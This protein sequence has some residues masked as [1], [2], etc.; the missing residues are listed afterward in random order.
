MSG[1]SYELSYKFYLS[2]VGRGF[3]SNNA[4]KENNRIIFPALTKPTCQH[5]ENE[6]AADEAGGGGGGGVGGTAA[7]EIGG[8]GVLI[9]MLEGVLIKTECPILFRAPPT[10]PTSTF[11]FAPS[12]LKLNIQTQAGK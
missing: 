7:G 1:L 3:T 11:C 9:K 10:P 4:S 5:I 12:P 8:L 2:T 6:T